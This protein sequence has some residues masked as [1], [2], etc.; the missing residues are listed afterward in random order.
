MASRHWHGEPPLARR[1]AAGTASRCWHNASRFKRS[2]LCPHRFKGKGCCVSFRLV[3]LF[4]P[5][6]QF[7]R[8]ELNFLRSVLG[9]TSN[10]PCTVGRD[11]LIPPVAM[12]HAGWACSHILPC[13]SERVPVPIDQRDRDSVLPSFVEVCSKREI[14]PGENRSDFLRLVLKNYC[15]DSLRTSVG[16]DAL[17]PPV[18]MRHAGWACSHIL[19][20]ISER[21][22]VPIDQRDRDSVLISH[23]SFLTRPVSRSGSSFIRSKSK[24]Q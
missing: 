7:G 8:N 9:I 14:R 17:I 23:I 11:A 2:H 6:I 18:A 12:R 3:C 10:S 22:P 16:R 5:E 21:V 19:P 13:F 24:S 1:A 15:L 4:F 20:C